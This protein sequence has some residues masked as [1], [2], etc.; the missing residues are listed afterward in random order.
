M[1]KNTKYKSDGP[2]GFT[3]QKKTEG[4]QNRSNSSS[5]SGL[6]KESNTAENEKE[7]LN[8]LN[9]FQLIGLDTKQKFTT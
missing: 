8:L 2:S 6:S 9:N 4:S 1:D 3:V 5:Q 7:S